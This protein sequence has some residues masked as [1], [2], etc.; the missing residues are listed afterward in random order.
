MVGPGCWQAG[1]P[2]GAKCVAC[3]FPFAVQQRPLNDVF[4]NSPIRQRLWWPEL[5]VASFVR[6]TQVV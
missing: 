4:N 6:S 2:P 5:F 3:Q 1:L